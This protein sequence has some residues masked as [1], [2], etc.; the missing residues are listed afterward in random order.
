M[1][2]EERVEI[3]NCCGL[4]DITL[5]CHSSASRC[6]ENNTFFVR[7]LK[8][9]LTQPHELNTSETAFHCRENMV[10]ILSLE[11]S[12]WEHE[13]QPTSW[14]EEPQSMYDEICPTTCAPIHFDTCLSGRL[15]RSGADSV[16]EPVVP[17]VWGIANDCIKED[18]RES[19]RLD[20]K[21]IVDDEIFSRY[22]ERDKLL[23]MDL[24][25]LININTMYVRADVRG[26]EPLYDLDRRAQETATA[27]ARVEDMTRPTVECPPNEYLCDTVG[28]VVCTKLTLH[29]DYESTPRLSSMVIGQVQRNPIIAVSRTWQ[30]HYLGTP[31]A[32]PFR[33]T[34][35]QF[36]TDAS[37]LCLNGFR[38]PP[39]CVRRSSMF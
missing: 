8:D 13:G 33:Y 39:S 26:S 5:L 22:T 35:S 20:G 12:A 15:D 25:A 10:C 32:R 1:V 29:R 9:A 34:L 11:Y 14:S 36:G 16:A 7:I 21:E 2:G 23:S 24:R 4:T 27:E 17:Y 38:K 6:E 28:G 19:M 37:T 18:R 3:L 30:P 31:V